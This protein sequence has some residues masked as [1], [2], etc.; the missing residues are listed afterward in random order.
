M[1]M[2][3]GRNELV[4]SVQLPISRT[5]ERSR[6]P[7]AFSERYTGFVRIPCRGVK[8]DKIQFH[9]GYNTSDD[10]AFGW[11]TL[12]LLKVPPLLKADVCIGTR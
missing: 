12:L 6:I 1:N 4:S 8:I 5:L 9:G 3:G 2:C 11:S 7:G 10:R